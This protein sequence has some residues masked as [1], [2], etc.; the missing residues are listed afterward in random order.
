MA[1]PQYHALA[2]A[3]KL[4]ALRTS[5]EDF[6]VFCRETLGYTAM[7]MEPHQAMCDALTLGGNRQLQLWPRGHFKSTVFTVAYSIW[8]LVREPN[9]RILIAN[10]RLDNSK[11]FLREIKSHFERNDKL[12]AIAGHQVTKD[13]KWTETEIIIKGRR[14]NLKEPSIQVA[15]VGQSMVSQH[16]DLIIMDD[17]VNNEN[18]STQEQ[19]QKT[20]DWYRLSISLLEPDGQTIIVGTRY[21]YADL[22]GFLLA[23]NRGEFR[24][25]LHSCYKEDGTPIFPSRFTKEHLDGVRYDQGSYIFSCQYLNEPT[26]EETAK[27]K[28]SWVRYYDD[29]DLEGK[30]LYTTYTV[31][32]AYS[33]AKT[34]DFTA[35]VVVSCD[36]DNNWYVRLALRTKEHEGKLVERMFDTHDYFKVDRTAVEQNAFEDTIKP[37]LEDEMRRRGQFFVVEGL[38]GKA[39]KV[40]RVEGLIPR[41]E[42]GTVF[43]KKDMDELEDELLRFPNAQ[44]DDLIDALA[45]HLQVARTPGTR[46]GIDAKA[47]AINRRSQESDEWL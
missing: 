26:D 22:Y 24:V 17:I 31:D 13:S 1:E 46:G 40:R 29:K 21:H 11:A 34:A 9:L 18:T 43:L 19:I 33:L 36:N 42:V 16:Y 47:R 6:F 12:R 35:H 37:A 5:T 25:E 38:R 28:K 3:A 30:Q 2:Y 32:R 8:R 44:H 23:N 45:Y 41:F 27:F 39:S 10:A 4:R 7:E 15:G 14:K 20:I